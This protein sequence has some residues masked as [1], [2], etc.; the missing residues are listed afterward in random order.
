VAI[1]FYNSSTAIGTN[2]KV[3]INPNGQIVATAGVSS[4]NDRLATIGYVRN[5][6]NLVNMNYYFDPFGRWVAVGGTVDPYNTLAAAQ[7]DYNNAGTG[8]KAVFGPDGTLLQ[9]NT[10]GYWLYFQIGR[11]LA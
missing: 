1:T 6:T 8:A 9:T 5:Q 3:L 11:F 2:A 10:S 7:N 4:N